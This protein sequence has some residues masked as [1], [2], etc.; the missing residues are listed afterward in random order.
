MYKKSIS[1]KNIYKEKKKK[2]KGQAQMGLA[3]Q[4]S[5]PSPFC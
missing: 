3:R 5:P 1:L 4:V 2:K